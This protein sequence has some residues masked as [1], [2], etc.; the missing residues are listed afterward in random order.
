MP[1]SINVSPNGSCTLDAIEEHLRKGIGDAKVSILKRKRSLFLTFSGS[2]APK[3]VV[4]TL[5]TGKITVGAIFPTGLALVFSLAKTGI[6]LFFFFNMGIVAG[7]CALVVMY[8]IGIPFFRRYWNPSAELVKR[9][10]ETE[11]AA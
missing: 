10:L 2:D 11:F 9:Q 6:A 1:K 3:K 5:M 4:V 7:V 8:A